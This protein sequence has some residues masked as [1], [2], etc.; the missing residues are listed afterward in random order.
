MLILY[1]NYG[2]IIE[3]EPEVKRLSYLPY[4]VKLNPNLSS[5]YQYTL[6]CL[7]ANNIDVDKDGN[8]NFTFLYTKNGLNTQALIISNR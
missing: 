7:Q 6:K 3:D 2:I 1:L 5:L 4:Y 8:S